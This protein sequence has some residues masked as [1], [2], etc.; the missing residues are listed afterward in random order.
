[1]LT[2]VIHF[3]ENMKYLK[4]QLFAV[5]FLLHLFSINLVSGQNL[6]PNNSFE[7]YTR[8]P[9]WHSMLNRCKGWN[10]PN[11]QYGTSD[12]FNSCFE[13][14]SQYSIES[15]ADVP[16]NMMGYQKA[17]KGDAYAGIFLYIKDSIPNWREYL[18][19]K[20]KDTLIAG[21]D[22][23]IKLKCSLADSALYA[24]NSLSIFISKSLE[25]GRGQPETYRNLYYLE[26]QLNFDSFISEKENW[27]DVEFTFHAEGGEK[28]MIIGNF[29]DDSNTDLI[30]LDPDTNFARYRSCYV[31]IDEVNLYPNKPFMHLFP[32]DTIICKNEKIVIDLENSSSLFYWSDGYIGSQRVIET[33]G[34][35]TCSTIID[36][37]VYRD[38]FKVEVLQSPNLE[39]IADT[40]ICDGNTI[41]IGDSCQYCTYRWN[42]LSDSPILRVRK[43]G[44]YTLEATNYCGV[45][46]DT[47]LVKKGL[48]DLYISNSFTPNWD[49]LNDN[50]RIYSPKSF[51]K[52]NLQI[53]NLWGEKIFQSSSP[54]KTWDGSYLN[55]SVPMGV[56]F[57]QLQYSFSLNEKTITTCGSIL[58]VR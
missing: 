19:T 13:L 28:C 9:E 35:Y 23:T 55:S 41:L 1:M 15:S 38:S 26:P 33:A 40:F 2:C 16:M 45:F 44:A 39:L 54:N 46:F 37:V 53:F 27:I 6:I 49:G 42:N 7:E 24:S 3:A 30:Q 43:E 18:F 17:S 14:D 11:K 21:Q 5:V 31:Y 47:I 20:F 25:T 52:F 4:E 36:G 10:T 22:Y 8:C 34:H 12:Y 29:S 58:L 56:Y 32:N 50:F 51:S 48:C 57:Y